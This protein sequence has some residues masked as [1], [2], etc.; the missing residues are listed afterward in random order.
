[1]DS[2]GFYV[3]RTGFYAGFY[4]VSTGFYTVSTSAAPEGVTA[5]GGVA[6]RTLSS[7]QVSPSCA[8]APLAPPCRVAP[9]RER[10]DVK[11]QRR[12]RA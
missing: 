11:R 12:M 3:N 8:A 2:T 4:T 5:L 10:T 7:A 9:K 1:M 6:G